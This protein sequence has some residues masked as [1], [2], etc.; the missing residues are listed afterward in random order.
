MSIRTYPIFFPDIIFTDV[1]WNGVVFEERTNTVTGEIGIYRKPNLVGGRPST[2]L[3]SYAYSKD[4]G[5]WVIRDPN[6][7][8]SDF[9]RF[10][11]GGRDFIPYDE[12]EKIFYTEGTELFN[13]DRATI[14]EAFSSEP[15]KSQFFVNGIPGIQ[16]PKTKRYVNF[17]GTYTDQNPFA[18]QVDPNDADDS[19]FGNP[20][21]DDIQLTAYSGSNGSTSGSISGSTNGN[22]SQYGIGSVGVSQYESNNQIGN[23]SSTSNRNG[24]G[25]GGSGLLKYPLLEPPAEFQYD[26]IMIQAFDYVAS[27]LKNNTNPLKNLG[28]AREITI[29]PMQPNISETNVVNWSDD[30]LNP[31][32]AAIGDFTFKTIESLGGDYTKML[33]IFREGMNDFKTM[34]SQEGIKSFAAAYFAGQAVGSNILGRSTG[35]VVNPNLELLFNG[36]NLRTFNF[37]FRFTPRYDKEAEMIRLIIRAFKRN[38]AVIREPGFLFLRSPRVFKLQYIYKGS[39]I[40]AGGKSDSSDL[41][42]YLNKIKP[43]ALTSFSVNYTPD[44]SYM[45]FNENGS[46]TCYQVDM[47]FSELM[48]IYEDELQGFEPNMGY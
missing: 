7:F 23:F 19:V 36:P 12:F 28:T 2:V 1:V 14:L 33:D 25:V 45:T 6:S 44:N 46:L 17:D 4:G 3:G 39:R 48:P 35:M 43:C 21:G 30:Q 18:Q 34:I 47:T 31:V 13:R 42:P 24:N 26:Y 41:H 9:N 11:G 37:S 5:E 22:G 16:D 8:V 10:S 40:P 38:S 32:K 27:G 20:Y 29:L 15:N